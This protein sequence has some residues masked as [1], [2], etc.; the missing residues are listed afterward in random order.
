MILV[1][2]S[3]GTSTNDLVS[4]LDAE[5]YLRAREV[6]T[7]IDSLKAVAG[8][9]PTD[10]KSQVA[11][12]LAIRL[13]GELKLGNVDEKQRIIASL[14][15]IAPGTKAQDSA[16]LAKPYALRAIKRLGGKATA[17]GR[18]AASPALATALA[19]FPKEVGFVGAYDTALASEGTSP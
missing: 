18:P 19:W 5:E 15:E 13:L 17:E 4:L 16:G 9:A 1:L 12:L 6:P 14:A 11:Q 2:F 8:K 10:G 3:G 7:S